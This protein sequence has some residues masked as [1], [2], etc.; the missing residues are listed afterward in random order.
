MTLS[1]L[2]LFCLRQQKRG[3]PLPYSFPTKEEAKRKRDELGGS[4]VVSYGPDHKLYEDKEA[5]Y[6]SR[7]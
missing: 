1:K 6:A 7:R 3:L 5:D 4:V 2:H